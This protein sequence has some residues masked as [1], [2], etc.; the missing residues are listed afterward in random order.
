MWCIKYYI[1]LILVFTIISCKKRDNLSVFNNFSDREVIGQFSFNYTNDVINFGG[2]NFGRFIL[3]SSLDE[4]DGY[5]GIVNDTL[6]LFKV[7]D[8]CT[9]RFPFCIIK[10]SKS[11]FFFNDQYC[12]ERISFDGVRV[13]TE[14]ITVINSDTIIKFTHRCISEMK[15]DYFLS[16]LELKQKLKPIYSTKERHFEVSLKKGI[17]KFESIHVKG[18]SEIYW[19]Y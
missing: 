8:M 14:G 15:I 9:E 12:S 19:P 2:K 6:F 7:K 16:D 11:T 1:F 13:T 17:I 5:W 3:K 10:K 18:I 4:I